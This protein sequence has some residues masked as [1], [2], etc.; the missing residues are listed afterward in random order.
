M[1]VAVGWIGLA[2]GS[3]ISVSNLGSTS[4]HQR[5]GEEKATGLA[6]ARQQTSRGHEKTKMIIGG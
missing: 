1:G 2:V 4:W 6:A 3:W 5:E